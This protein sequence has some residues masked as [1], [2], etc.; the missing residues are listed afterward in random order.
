M[1]SV[2]V[3][4]ISSDQHPRHRHDL[5][6]AAAEEEEVLVEADALLATTTA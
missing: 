2:E 4:A 5:M 1:N 3:T 6:A